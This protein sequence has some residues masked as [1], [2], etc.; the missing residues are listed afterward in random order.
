M[1]KAASKQNDSTNNSKM[2]YKLFFFLDKTLSR[3]KQP[4]QR[5]ILRIGCILS[6]PF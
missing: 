3:K 6:V 4:A 1:E 5:K 2:Q